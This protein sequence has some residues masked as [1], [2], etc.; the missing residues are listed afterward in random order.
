LAAQRKRPPGSAPQPERT[1]SEDLQALRKE[2]NNLVG[3]WK[4]RTGQPHGVIHNELRRTCGGPPA[5][6]ASGDDLR[7]RIAK[8]RDWAAKRA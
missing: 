1:A 5:A 3:A 8:I 7:K 6:Q 4:H 2:L